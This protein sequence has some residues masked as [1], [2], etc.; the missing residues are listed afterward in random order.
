MQIVGSFAEFER[1]MLRE[2]TKSGLAAA[3]QDGRVGG[4]RPKL[5]P[6]SKKEIVSLVTSGQKTGADAARLFR[7]HPS[8]VG[9][10]SCQTPD[11]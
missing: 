3:R 1:A 7:V 9:A 5:T 6:N 11:D 4:R 8:T 2:R 10:A